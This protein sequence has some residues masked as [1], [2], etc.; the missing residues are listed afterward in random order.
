MKKIAMILAG[1]G[2]KDGTEITEAVSAIVSLSQYKAHVDF[3]APDK[4]FV[5]QNFLTDQKTEERNILIESARITRSQTQDLKKLK[6]SAYDALILPGGFGVALSLCDWAQKGASCHVD[7]TVEKTI[8]DFYDEEKPVGAI[9]IAPA[10]VAR[11]LGNHNISV[12]IGSDKETALEI[13]KT[14]A[15]HIECPVDDFVSDRQHKIVTTPAYM[16]AQATP[17]QVFKGISGLVKELVEMS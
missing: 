14:G 1:C 12:T 13:E 4:S 11:V 5:S 7:P 17:S 6:S 9:C 15:K 8:K 10:L 3:F 16:Y 2:N